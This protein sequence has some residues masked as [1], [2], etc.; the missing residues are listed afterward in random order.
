MKSPVLPATG[1]E[2]P[3]VLPRMRE[4]PDPDPRPNGSRRLRGVGTSIEGEVGQ[5]PVVVESA[6][7]GEQEVGGGARD[8]RPPREG[9]AY[10]QAEAERHPLN[11][12]EI[13][14]T[15]GAAVTPRSTKR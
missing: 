13:E 4:V 10:G 11:W 2:L 5:T 12:T 7:A 15:S 14:F 3:G 6:N 9:L 1:A 8:A